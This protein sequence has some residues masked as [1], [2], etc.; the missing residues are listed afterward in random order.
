MPETTRRELLATAGVIGGWLAVGPGLSV[1]SVQSSPGSSDADG[2]YQLPPLPYDYADLEPHI[3]AQTM[4]LHHDVHHAGY[5]R[6]AN[7]AIRE[8]ESIRRTGGDQI[9]KVR[10]VTDV[11]SFNASGHLLHT[12][13]WSNMKRNGGGRPPSGGSI[14]RM[15]SRDFGT[16]DAFQAHFSAAAA[17]V[18]GSGW[19]ILAYEPVAQRLVILQVEKHNNVGLPGAIPLLVLDVWEHAYYLRHQNKRTE[20]IQA[21]WNVINWEDVDA[22]LGAGR[23]LG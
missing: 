15:L 16:F 9:H 4:K 20:Y 3:D 19:A 17:Q 7:L 13:F 10:A 8:L 6:G 1:A 22:R 23:K 12:V 5:V 11:L 18:Q 2:P 21:F 14:D